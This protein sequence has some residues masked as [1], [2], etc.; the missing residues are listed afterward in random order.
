SLKKSTEIR[1]H[2]TAGTY[3]KILKDSF[4]AAYHYR[5]NIEKGAPYY[6]KRKKVYFQDPF[7]FHSCRSW[8][9]GKDGFT[10]SLDFLSNTQNRSKLVEC[11][12]SNHISRFMFSL[13]PSSL[14]DPSNYVFYWRNK[15]TEIDFTIDL[16]GKFLPI[17]VKYSDNIGKEEAKPI[18]DFIK[19]GRSHDYGIITSKNRLEKGKNYLLIP[20]S[21]LLLLT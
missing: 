17:E 12:V 10:A 7:I 16:E 9:Y 11:V 5:L 19:T 1:D 13:H 18:S 3:V 20:L 21:T 6:R 15:K 2:K 14:Y 8:V 4:V